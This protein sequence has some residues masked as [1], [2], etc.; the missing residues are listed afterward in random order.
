[1]LRDLLTTSPSMPV[2]TDVCIIGA[3]PA[4]L[5]LGGALVEHGMKVVIL[6]AG[7]AT[8]EIRDDPPDLVF[9]RREYRG[10]TRGRAHGFG[11]TSSL[12]GGQ[13]LPV[14]A[15]E[16]AARPHIGAPAW[17]IDHEEIARYFPRLDS[18]LN[19]TSLPFELTAGGRAKSPLASL[20]W[21]GFEPRISKWIPFAGR[22]LASAWW[23]SLS[24]TGRA[25]AWVNATVVGWDSTARADTLSTERLCAEAPNGNTLE[26]RPRSVAICAG[27]LES[28]RL[29]IELLQARAGADVLGRFLHDHLSVRVAEL[30][31]ADR[32]GFVTLFCPSFQ[33]STMRSPRLE[34]ASA[35]AKS[36]GVPAM[37]AHFVVEAPD[38]S[39]FA[40]VRDALRSFQ[41]NQPAVALRQIARLPGAIPDLAEIAWWRAI[42]KRLTLPAGARVYVH[43]DFE[44]PPIADNRVHV[45]KR[46]L[47][48]PR[49]RLHVDWDLPLDP[50]G[51]VG[52]M[53]EQL[54]RF[55]RTNQLDRF[56]SLHLNDPSD[57]AR[58]WPTNTYDIYHPAGTTR[59]SRTPL[60]GAVDSDLMLYGSDNVYVLSSS[61]FPSMGS[62][63]PTY[64]LMALGLRLSSHLAGRFGISHTASRLH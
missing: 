29:A 8:P 55:W 19:V 15:E 35:V 1:M 2:M 34:L 30:E 6:D 60:E 16:M 39:G 10:A 18:L 56:A 4:G 5:S 50:S 28:P 46:R 58:A 25:E 40:F 57:L 24:R 9:D 14:R 51:I 31:I 22:N 59:M 20:N 61:V 49:G 41:R 3:G 38:D 26:V 36:A 33:G 64:T 54:Q 48:E 13:L 62:A 32:S 23:P 53:T 37:Y 43:V 17:P 63:N 11:G 42:R 12:W 52:V 47:S 27:A 7:P 44:Q 45:E 21:E